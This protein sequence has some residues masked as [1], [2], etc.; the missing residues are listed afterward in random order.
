MSQLHM[1]LH[2]S[3]LQM[4]YLS[5]LVAKVSPDSTA[6]P[7]CN[8]NACHGAVLR[9]NYRDLHLHSFQN[10]DGITSFYS[11]SNTCFYLAYL[12]RYRSG[13][14]YA[15]S[16]CCCLGSGFRCCLRSCLRC[17]FGS[18]CRCCCASTLFLLL[19]LRHMQFRL[20]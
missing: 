4:I 17:C 6:S 13:Y 11:L 15:A 20:L 8:I 3:N 10:D 14:F 12:A 2:V 1:Y 18:C 5:S 9:S 16:A 19:R 7:V